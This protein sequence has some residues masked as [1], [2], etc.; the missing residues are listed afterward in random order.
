MICGP[1]FKIHKKKLGGE[2]N[3]KKTR[4]MS[5]IVAEALG[6][7]EIG[8]MLKMC[9]R[10]IGILI[11]FSLFSCTFENIYIKKILKYFIL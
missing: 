4:S 9:N 8:W 2:G 11:E 3:K 1:F 10:Y 6:Q 5:E 7:K